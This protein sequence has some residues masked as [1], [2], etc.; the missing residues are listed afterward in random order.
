[1]MKINYYIPG[2]ILI[3]LAFVLLVIPEIL[4]ALVAAATTV[5]GISALYAGHMIR[6]AMDKRRTMEKGMVDDPFVTNPLW[7]SSDYVQ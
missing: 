6:R 3:L 2:A 5:L 4:V 7:V 1:M